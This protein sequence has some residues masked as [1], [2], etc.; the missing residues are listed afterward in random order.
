VKLSA[1]GLVKSYRGRRVVDDV[2]L[3]LDR[4]EVVGLLGPNGA[5]KTTTFHM[6]T[7]FIR[8]EAGQVS[9]NGRDIT[10][11]PVFQRAR[12]GLGYLSQEPS[13]FRKLSVRDNI[14]AVLEL[15]GRSGAECRAQSDA[16]LE[17]LNVA[18]LADQKAA[19]LSGGERRRVE[20]A[21]ALAPQPGFLLLDEPF[22]GI[23]PIVRAEIQDIIRALKREGLGILI[24]DHNV[25]E[26][27]EITDRAYIMFDARV[28]VSGTSQALV[29]DPK[30]REVYLGARFRI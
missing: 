17:K 5:G 14:R 6:V 20:L 24:T 25:R 12:L 19:T 15:L 23:D 9:L 21:R 16:L 4:G 30:A 26:T 13:V 22:T 8:P 1:R 28:L 2:A 7:G 27:L 10:R 18:H 11:M 29:D 3:E